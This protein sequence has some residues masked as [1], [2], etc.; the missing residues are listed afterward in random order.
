VLSC[1]ETLAE[2]I[3]ADLDDPE[4]RPTLDYHQRRIT[5]LIGT[6]PELSASQDTAAG[7]L[8]GFMAVGAWFVGENSIEQAAMWPTLGGIYLYALSHPQRGDDD[9]TGFFDRL[10]LTL[11]E[12][13]QPAVDAAAT[14]AAADLIRSLFA[15]SP[16]VPITPTTLAGFILGVLYATPYLEGPE[17]RSPHRLSGPHC[18][19]VAANDLAHRRLT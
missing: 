8:Y 13:D 19:I 14:S 15:G 10:E 11:G 9:P 17:V 7:F 12:P 1:F 4:H 2:G 16:D 6:Q 5:D 18:L 3:A